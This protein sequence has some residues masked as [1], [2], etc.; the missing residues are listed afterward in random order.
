M[1]ALLFFVNLFFS[2][3][4]LASLLYLPPNLNTDKAKILVVIHGCLQSAESMALGTG[5]NQIAQLNN[6]VVLY[7]QVPE[8]S[9]PMGC[10]SWYSPENQRADS[11][12]LKVIMDEIKA[13]QQLLGLKKSSVFVAGISSG[14]I[15]ATG[16]LACYPNEFKAGAIHS[17]A[18][19]GLAQN[20]KEAE[21]LLKVGPEGLVSKGP[22]EP[23]AFQGSILV[24]QGTA[25]AVV[26][27]QNALRV[28]ADFVGNT[29]AVSTK[30]FKAGD[31]VYTVADYLS[32][33][34]AKGRLVM[35]QG[36]DH[37]WAGFVNNLRF[38]NVLGPKGTFPTN[39]PFFTELGPSSTNLIW[40][41]FKATDLQ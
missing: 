26:N 30:E 41:Y 16:L 11:G 37:A 38:G 10:W 21:K 28:I 14:A 36:L 15:T 4:V 31:L 7:P 6:M 29:T 2:N 22:C 1:T 40:E 23:S 32:N 3:T 34:P 13:T 20:V 25:D 39:V 35:V 9:H 8:L 27:P 17:G 18:S 24:L 19:Y 12:Q 33:K 5:W